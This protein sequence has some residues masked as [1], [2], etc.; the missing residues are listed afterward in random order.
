MISFVICSIDAGKFNAIKQNIAQAMDPAPYE[1]VGVHDARSL[2]E[3]Y[4]RGAKVARGESLVFCHD[5]I[6]FL[7]PQI[8]TRI[9]RHLQRFDI[10]GVAGTDRV[11]GGLWSAAG[12]PYIYGQVAHSRAEPNCWDISIFSN[13]RPVLDKIHCLDGLFIAC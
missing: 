5:D 8:G 1:I 2:C 9:E 6:E 3:G 4:N 7:T 10:V 12:P 13:A 11:I